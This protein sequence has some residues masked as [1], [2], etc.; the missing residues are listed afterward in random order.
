MEDEDDE[1]KRRSDADGNEGEL[2]GRSIGKTEEG[3]K[4]EGK[5]RVNEQ[6]T[7]REKMCG[8]L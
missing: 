6:E 3:A 7:V 8:A 1:R 5:L 4:Y 2:V